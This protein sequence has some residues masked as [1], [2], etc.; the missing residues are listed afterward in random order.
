MM[1]E[2]IGFSK[3]Q[4]RK[5]SCSNCGAKLKYTKSD[6]FTH[7]YTCC[8]SPESDPAINCP[9]CNRVVIVKSY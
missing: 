4:F 3:K 7:K 8:G 6:I 1:V 5:T 2:V 9:N